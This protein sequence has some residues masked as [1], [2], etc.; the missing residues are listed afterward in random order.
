PGRQWRLLD[1][2][3]TSGTPVV[4]LLVAGRPYFLHD[5]PERSAAVLQSFF[6]GEEGAGALAG[7][8]SGRV[9]P[10]G[11]LPVSVPNHAGGQP[12]GYL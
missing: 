1:A 6:P 12:G 3:L 2:V 7:V 10:S 4:T 11:R 5:A 8:I 9:N